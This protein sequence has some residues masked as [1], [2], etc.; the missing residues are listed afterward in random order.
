MVTKLDSE[1]INAYYSIRGVVIPEIGL[2]EIA[3]Y[4]PDKYGKKTAP[5]LKSSTEAASDYLM[6]IKSYLR[7]YGIPITIES[8][9]ASYDW[10]IGNLRKNGLY[11]AP[12]AVKRL[13]GEIRHLMQP[14][15]EQLDT[16]VDK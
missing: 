14:Q 7:F 15:A 11:K 3:I 2:I 1:F 9:T 8:L 5:E 4:Y 10:G 6:I 13:I 16:L 12:Y